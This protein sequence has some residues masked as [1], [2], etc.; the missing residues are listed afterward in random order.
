MN[1]YTI[2]YLVIILFM[3]FKNDIFLAIIDFNLKYNTKD[4]MNNILLNKKKIIM[5]FFV[6]YFIYKIKF[7]YKIL[8]LILSIIIYL[9]Y[10]K[11]NFILNQ[12]KAIY[13]DKFLINK[14]IL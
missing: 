3:M 14:F 11:I 9:N 8:I 4:F 2:F 6:F 5:C 12:F 1:Y 7:I 13:D 10:T